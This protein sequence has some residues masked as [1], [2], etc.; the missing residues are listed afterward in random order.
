MNK[1]E[2][3]KECAKEGLIIYGTTWESNLKRLKELKKYKKIVYEINNERLFGEYDGVY[4]IPSNSPKNIHKKIKE[5][6]QK[7]FPKPKEREEV[8]ILTIKGKPH[9]VDNVI[10]NI[11]HTFRNSAHVDVKWGTRAENVQES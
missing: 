11:E 5:I 7:Y 4:G 10:F 8:L 3:L 6:I 2:F 9:E 1:E